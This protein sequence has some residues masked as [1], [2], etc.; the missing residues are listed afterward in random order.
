MFLQGSDCTHLP[1][2][3]SYDYLCHLRV[4]EGTFVSKAS[5]RS[6]GQDD[7]SEGGSIGHDGPTTYKTHRRFS[8]SDR[9]TSVDTTA[10]ASPVDAMVSSAP[11]LSS[12]SHYGSVL[13]SPAPSKYRTRDR[14]LSPSHYH[15]LAM[16]GQHHQQPMARPTLHRAITDQSSTALHRQLPSLSPS[17]H[18]RYAPLSDEDRRALS[19]LRVEF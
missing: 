18:G 14:V 4:P 12:G 13:L 6:H 17:T 7:E 5:A 15:H 10:A 19:R 1:I 8:L 3:D 16:H 2:V 9:S 11:R